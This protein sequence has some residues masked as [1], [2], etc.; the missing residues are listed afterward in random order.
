MASLTSPTLPVPPPAVGRRVTVLTIDGGGIR[1]LI[2]GTI[3]AFLEK[4]LQEHDGPDARLADYFD[5]IAGTSTGGL[6]TA[7]LAAPGKDKRPLFS[8]KKIN[9]FY[10]ENGPHIFPQRPW[11]EVVNTLIEIKGPKY[12]G[13][14]LHSK[15]QSLLGATRMHDTL[16]NIVI[17]TFDV[18]NLQ[19]TIF[20]TFDAQTMPLKDALLSDVCIST[21]AAPTY[22]PAHFFQTR[23]EATGKTRDFNLIDGGVSANN[24]TLLTINQITR[25]MIV[26]KQDLFPGGPKDYDKFLV[27]SIGTGSAKN[28]AVYTAKDAAGWG[29]LSWLH[30]KDGYTPIVDMFSYSS[31]ALVDYNVSILFQALRSEKN[32]LRIQEDS[33]M[34]AAATVDVATREN[35]EELVRIGERMLAKTVSRVDMETG[36]HVPVL[37]EG[38]NADALARFAEM[39]S[40]ERKARTSSSSSQGKARQRVVN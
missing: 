23:D 20:S 39:L 28:A 26:D 15:I 22:L 18:K 21:S 11:P 17:P 14:F 4:K 30:S 13:K 10:T 5:Y 38:T 12:D 1:G 31:A 32:Y 16:T 34:G 36:K 29:I 8:A 40:Q 6:I 7:M 24:P 35:M 25:K 3:L 33:L 37:E 9:E 19:P 2:P 27:I